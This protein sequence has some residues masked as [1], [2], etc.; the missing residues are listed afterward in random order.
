MCVVYVVCNPGCMH[1]TF[2]EKIFR[3]LLAV[4]V[5]DNLGFCG[6]ELVSKCSMYVYV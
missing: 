3:S 1:A 2:K 4:R 5:L 6:S